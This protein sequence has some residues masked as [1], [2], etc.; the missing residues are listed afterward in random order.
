MN[1]SE[2]VGLSTCQLNAVVS[3]SSHNI[4]SMASGFPLIVLQCDYRYSMWTDLSVL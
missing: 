1:D 4:V 2:K 3:Y